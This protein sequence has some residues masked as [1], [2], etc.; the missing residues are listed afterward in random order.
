[1]SSDGDRTF[2]NLDGHQLVL[3]AEMENSF[4]LI[5]QLSNI[6][7]SNPDHLF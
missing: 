3:A 2:Q 7:Q 4:T 1:M 5:N 6:I